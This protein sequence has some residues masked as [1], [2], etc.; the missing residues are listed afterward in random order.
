MNI[1]DIVSI[2]PYYITAATNLN[3][4]DEDNDDS[5]LVPYLP[6]NIVSVNSVY[7]H[8]AASVQQWYNVKFIAD[9]PFKYYYENR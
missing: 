5:P 8:I 7:R 4:I 3:K 1:I 6:N 9:F 2:I